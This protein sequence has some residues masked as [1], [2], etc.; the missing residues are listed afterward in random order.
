[1]LKKIIIL[2]LF[3]LP[4]VYVGMI[5]AVGVHEILGHG[6]GAELMGHT[7]T[8]FTLLPDG[9]G[10]ANY[11]YTHEITDFEN[12]FILLAGPVST[13]I[14]SIIFFVLAFSLR[15]KIFASLTFLVL[16]FTQL[17]DGAPYML[18]NS[19]LP[20]EPGDFGGVLTIVPEYRGLFIVLGA[21]MLIFGI[22]FF[23]MY[24]F[25]LIINWLGNISTFLTRFLVILVLFFAQAGAWFIF[26]WNQLAPGIGFWPQITA[27]V[28]TGLVSLV[29]LFHKP[30]TEVSF[31]SHE[32]ILPLSVSWLCF[33]V[34]FLSTLLYFSHGVS[35]VG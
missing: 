28:I 6:V 14:A 31:E 20:V 12:L 15:K 35:L 34:V 26:D 18:W 4:L 24:V 1:M 21:S 19:I 16:G 8:K 2:L 29:L 10:W 3:V 13:Y 22:I 32:C 23:N 30:N 27:V 11:D 33:I 17:M 5:L 9:M 25:R 7:F